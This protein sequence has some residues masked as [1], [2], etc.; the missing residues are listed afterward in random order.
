MNP[1]N[2]RQRVMRSTLWRAATR[3]LAS[4]LLLACALPAN[5]VLLS[6]SVGFDIQ[7]QTRGTQPSLDFRA[8][9]PLFDATL[10]TLQQVD[11]V[12]NFDLTLDINIANRTLN[13]TTVDLGPT[14]LVIEGPRFF[15]R[16]NFSNLTQGLGQLFCVISCIELTAGFISNAGQTLALLV[17]YIEANH[18]HREIHALLREGTRQCARVCI[19]VLQ[20]DRHKNDSGGMLSVI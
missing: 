13:P 9:V 8:A 3:S 15:D 12:Y 20:T 11:I 7:S 5:A 2:L 17:R 1:L 6:H 4:A 18:V 14:S 19:T 16:F 10:G